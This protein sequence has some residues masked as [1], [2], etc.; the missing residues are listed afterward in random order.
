MD[1]CGV[2]KEGDYD[3]DNNDD[4]DSGN[5]SSDDDDDDD[6]DDGGGG[7]DDNGE[8]RKALNTISCETLDMQLKRRRRAEGNH[9]ATQNR[10]V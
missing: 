8:D 1:C 6:D 9:N 7:G 5:A 10:Y 3:D 2:R 4:D